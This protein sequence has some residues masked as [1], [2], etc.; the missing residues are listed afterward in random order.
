MLVGAT[1]I[2][3]LIQTELLLLWESMEIRYVP[4]L[5]LSVRESGCNFFKKKGLWHNPL[6]EIKEEKDKVLVCSVT[7][8]VI[9]YFG[10]CVLTFL[11]PELSFVLSLLPLSSKIIKFLDISRINK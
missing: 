7:T 10:S 1:S 3:T 9:C 4:E 5:Q 6:S 8:V 11:S 2:R